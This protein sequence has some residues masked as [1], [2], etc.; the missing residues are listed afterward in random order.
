MQSVLIRDMTLDDV[1]ALANGLLRAYGDARNTVE[2]LAMRLRAGLESQTK[3]FI[4]DDGGAV[5][6]MV[7]VYDYSTTCF[8]ALMGVEPSRQRS[9]VGKAIMAAMCEWLDHERG[10][11]PAELYATPQGL[12]LYRQYGFVVD[13]AAGIWRGRGCGAVELGAVRQATLADYDAIVDLDREA[14]GAARGATFRAT[15][16]QSSSTVFVADGGFAIAQHAAK[17]LGPVVARDRDTALALLRAAS[18][19]LADIDHRVNA[20]VRDDAEAMLREL[21]YN[22]D[23]IAERMVRGT[24]PPGCREHIWT[25]LNLGQG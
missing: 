10:G 23:V 19:A 16:E 9:G 11:L 5:I 8:V 7:L 17:V 3:S 25:A 18:G 22:R 21:G 24:L 6:G 13:G 20:P 1:P 14:F 2:A 12:G 15:V 4:A